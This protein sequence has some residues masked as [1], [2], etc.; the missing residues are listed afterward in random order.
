MTNRTPLP[1]V[2]K[3]IVSKY[4]GLTVYVTDEK[5]KKARLW[6]KAP[7]LR[8]YLIGTASGTA[9]DRLTN[10]ACAIAQNMHIPLISLRYEKGG[11]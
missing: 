6:A 2:E 11:K 7:G 4:D 9:H 5:L 3:T 10:M 1:D 8:I